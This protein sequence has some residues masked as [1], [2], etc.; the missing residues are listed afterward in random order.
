MHCV[1][2]RG[3][4]WDV[5]PGLQVCS[6]AVVGSSQRYGAVVQPSPWCTYHI[7]VCGFFA[8]SENDCLCVYSRKM[9]AYVSMCVQC[10]AGRQGLDLLRSSHTIVFRIWMWVWYLSF[11]R[12]HSPHYGLVIHDAHTLGWKGTATSFCH[13]LL[14]LCISFVL[15]ACNMC[16]ARLKRACSIILQVVVSSVA[17]YW[18]VCGL[19]PFCAISGM[20]LLASKSARMR[21][22]AH[23]RDGRDVYGAFKQLPPWSTYHIGFCG[24]FALSDND[25]L[26]LYSRKMI[27]Y[28]SMCVSVL[29]DVRDLIYYVALTPL[30]LEC[31]CEFDICLSIGDT[32]DIMD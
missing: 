30:S 18:P 3:Y 1:I 22:S 12:W 9:I 17:H 32:L 7:G 4:L 11:N 23:P 14:C 27:A 5:S 31:E 16:V 6:D 8:L 20:C 26:C 25:C 2:S 19:Y 15:R 13:I 29:H 28:V 21:W 10:F 24:F